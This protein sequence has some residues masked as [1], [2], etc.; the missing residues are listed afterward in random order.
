[1]RK[2]ISPVL[3]TLVLLSVVLSGRA[4]ATPS[5][6]VERIKLAPIEGTTLMYVDGHCE[7]RFSV[8]NKDVRLAIYTGSATKGAMRLRLPEGAMSLRGFAWKSSNTQVAS[9]SQKG[10]VTAHKVGKATITAHKGDD[11]CVFY[12]RVHKVALA[13]RRVDVPVGAT[14]KVRLAG[15]AIK[16]VKSSDASVVR[17]TKT[18]GGKTVRVGGLRAGKATITVRTAGGKTLQCKVRVMVARG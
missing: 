7:S 17:V 8:G 4:W 15:D 9:V 5:Q 12:V 14:A 11:E 3:L 1:M 13:Q 18:K 10:V 6:D 2:K 16:S